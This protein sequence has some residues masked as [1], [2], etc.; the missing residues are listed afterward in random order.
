MNVIRLTRTVHNGERRIVLHFGYD[1]KLTGMVKVMPGVRW[2][3]T[4]KAWHIANYPENLK[5]I[6]STFKGIAEVDKSEIFGGPEYR[7]EE[8]Q[9]KPSPAEPKPAVLPVLSEKSRIKTG[10]FRI[11]ME[12]QRYSPNTVKTYMEA[13]T[14]FLRYFHNKE[15]EAI[16]NADLVE[17]NHRYILG[18][19][20]S[21]S[22]Q[23]QVIN[24]VKLFFLKV[25]NRKLEISQIERPGREQKLPDILS[26]EEVGNMLRVTENLKHKCLIAVIYSCGLRRSEAINLKLEDIDRGRMLIK[27]RGAKGKKD[28]YVQLA[29]SIL[30]LL[31]NYYLKEKPKIWVFEGVKGSQYSATSISNDIKNAAKKAGIRK[32]VYPHILRHSFATHHLEQGTDLR[33]IQEWLGHASSKTTE[34]YTHVSENTFNKF[35]NPIDDFDL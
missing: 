22:F 21:A 4:L 5:L 25:E 9:E 26:K 27:I 29:K 17:F 32:R 2:S 30:E 13:I 6:F 3:Q 15:P 8:M 7:N 12:Q 16:S 24:A 33:Y 23:N 11:W 35:R 14:T 20:Y 34:R 18:N 19:N 10:E 28:R 31:R 1:P